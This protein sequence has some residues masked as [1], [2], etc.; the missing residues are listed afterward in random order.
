M[1]KNLR[2]NGDAGCPMPDDIC[3]VIL[4]GLYWNMSNS[5]NSPPPTLNKD[6]LSCL[7]FAHEHGAQLFSTAAKLAARYDK[8]DCLIY[9]CEHGGALDESAL[10]EALVCNRMQ[11]LKYLREHGCTYKILY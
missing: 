10:I 6:V 1:G 7:K 2:T 3:N 4:G 11:C 9:V 8:L 5:I